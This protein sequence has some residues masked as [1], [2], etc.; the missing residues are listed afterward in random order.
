MENRNFYLWLNG[1]DMNNRT[2]WI[3]YVGLYKITEY[4]AI[5]LFNGCTDSTALNYDS[6]ANTR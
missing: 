2:L 5:A 3:D 4:T 6:L 1:W